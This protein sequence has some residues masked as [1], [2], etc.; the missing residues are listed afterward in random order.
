MLE[1]SV[2]TAV[3]RWRGFLPVAR[4][5]R[6]ML[7]AA[8]VAAGVAGYVTAAGCRPAYESRADVLVGR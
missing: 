4:R 1:S 8:A 3:R 6:W 5:W 7:L 2:P